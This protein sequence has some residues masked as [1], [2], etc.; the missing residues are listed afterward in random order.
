MSAFDSAVRQ[1]FRGW[2]HVSTYTIPDDDGYHV[3]LSL[4]SRALQATP[5]SKSEIVDRLFSQSDA[6]YAVEL[7]KAA[8]GKMQGLR[9]YGRKR[10]K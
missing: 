1:M 7:V 10:R 4:S 6:R 2:S 8:R 9:F 5:M 3:H